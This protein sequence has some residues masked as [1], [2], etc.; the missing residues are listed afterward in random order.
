MLGVGVHADFTCVSSVVGDDVV[1][2]DDGVG[3]VVWKLR[4]YLLWLM[5]LHSETMVII[6]ENDVNKPKC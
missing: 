4:H 5:I 2:I 1:A 3:V 6:N